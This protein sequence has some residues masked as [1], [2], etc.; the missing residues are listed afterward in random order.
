MLAHDYDPN[1][2]D[3]RGWFV[4]EKLDG[5]RVWW[6]GGIT[7]G[8]LTTSIPWANLSSSSDVNKQKN[9]RPVA[10]G[11]WTRLGNVVCA[12]DYFLDQLPKDISLDGEMWSDRQQFQ[13]IRSICSKHAP[14]YKEWEVIKFLVFDSPSHELVFHDRSVNNAQFKRTIIADDCIAYCKFVKA[15]FVVGR[16][17]NFESTYNLLKAACPTLVLVQERLT[18]QASKLQEDI[19]ARLDI[20]TGKR[21]EGLMLRAPNSFWTSSRSRYLLK[22][23]KLNVG[24]GIV[25]GYTSGLGKYQGMLG[26][27]LLKLQSGRLLNISGFTDDERDFNDIDVQSWCD[28]NPGQRLPTYFPGD[29]EKVIEHPLYKMN[30]EVRFSYTELSDDGI[31][32]LARYL[33]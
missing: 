26:S 16:V 14:I 23:K 24:E 31:P 1:K 21:G 11:L 10:T 19:R 6:D 12:P 28:R 32:K 30:Q 18:D 22:V 9:V 2:D 33:R 29:N 27:V 7:R 4:S 3:V 13:K 15:D 8:Q 5:F 25:V 17:R 20:V